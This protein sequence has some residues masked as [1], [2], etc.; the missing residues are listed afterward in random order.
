MSCCGGIAVH[1]AGGHVV[2]EP[3]PERQ[4][5]TVTPWMQR[6]WVERR[7]GGPEEAND[8]TAELA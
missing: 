2:Q 8:E 7:S 1:E 5:A 6:T 3:K 4:T